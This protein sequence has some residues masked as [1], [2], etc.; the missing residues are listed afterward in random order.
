MKSK[1]GREGWGAQ[2]CPCL[3]RG[4]EV[5]AEGPGQSQTGGCRQPASEPSV[6]LVPS[7]SVCP[8]LTQAGGSSMAAHRRGQQG[9]GLEPQPPVSAPIL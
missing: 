4:T 6:H 7:V 9:L 2:V 5:L 1:S 3:S 8:G